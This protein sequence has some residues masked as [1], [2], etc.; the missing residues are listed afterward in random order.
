M[1]IL[2]GLPTLPDIDPETGE[3]EQLVYLDDVREA[4]KRLEAKL[5]AA[6]FVCA[7]RERELLAIKGPCSSKSEG[8]VL[9]YAHAGPCDID[10]RRES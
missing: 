10:G 9:H 1:S 4:V 6:R 7:E 2:D 8:C 5:A 3:T